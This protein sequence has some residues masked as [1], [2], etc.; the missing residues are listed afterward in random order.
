MNTQRTCP[1]C[2]KPVAADAPQGLCGECLMKGGMA[3]TAGGPGGATGFVPPSVHEIAQLFPQLDVLELIGHGGMGAVYKARQPGLDRL[4]ALKILPPRPGSDPGFA[5]RFMREARAL[6][7]LTHPNIVAVYDFGQ[8]GGL[9][10]F[11]MEYV[12]G[13]NLRQVEQSAKLSPSE[14]LKLIPQICEALQFAHDEGIVHRDIK[15]EN[16]LLDKKGRVKIAD[17]GLAKLL[18]QEPQNFRLTGTRDVMGTP[19]YMAPEQ[20]EH[21]QAVD[22]RADIYSLGVVFYE[23]LTGELPLGRFGPPSSRARDVKIDVRLDEVVLRA[24]EREPERRYQQASQVKTDVESIAGQSGRTPATATADHERAR[25]EV[26]APSFGLLA[27]GILNWVLLPLC[28]G[29]LLPAFSRAHALS[30]LGPSKLAVLVLV[31]APFAFCSFI[32]YAALKMQRLEAYRVAVAASILA[33][34]VTPG[35]LI[36]FPVGIWALMTLARRDVRAAFHQI[37]IALPQGHPGSDRSMAFRFLIWGGAAAAALAILLTGR[38]LLRDHR[39]QAAV[40][41]VLFASTASDRPLS[42]ELET[43]DGG[44]FK[45]SCTST[46]VFR[47]FE[48]PDPGVDR[49]TLLYQAR[50]KTAGLAGRAYLEMYCRFP[51]KGEFFSRGLENPVSGTTGWVTTQTPFFL[52]QG[53]KPDLIRLNLVVEGPGNV[54]LRDIRLDSTPNPQ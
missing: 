21:P 13:P 10:Y 46:K 40:P 35:N 15:P 37:R 22:H 25:K 41:A 34:L 42:E 33:M 51:G 27:T 48:V 31:V 30:P 17:F 50:L 43:V 49:C 45:V 5:D 3:S 7:K 38:A 29:L 19:H 53:E 39:A 8:A 2:G 52:K 23:M 12:D 47:L 26:R 44:A 36:G 1:S 20:V 16:V 14:A 11:I 4:V 24:L 6:A 32:I 9:H 28:M 54:F 18:G